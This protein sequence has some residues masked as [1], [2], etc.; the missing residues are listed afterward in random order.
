[1]R[2][3]RVRIGHFGKKE[4]AGGGNFFMTFAFSSPPPK[5]FDLSPDFVGGGGDEKVGQKQVQH[6][7]YL[8]CFFAGIIITLRCIRGEKRSA[9]SFFYLGKH[10]LLLHTSDAFLCLDAVLV[11]MAVG[12]TM[13]VHTTHT[14]PHT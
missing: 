3:K 8:L 14:L 6:F 12:C 1:M 7:P 4:G 5:H 9:Q 13:L 2:E 11:N 10:L